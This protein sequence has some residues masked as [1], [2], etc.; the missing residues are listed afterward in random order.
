MS[1]RVSYIL[2]GVMVL[3]LLCAATPAFATNRI[4]L[5]VDKPSLTIGDLLQAEVVVTLEDPDHVRNITFPDFEGFK[6][7]NKS[8]GR[9]SYTSIVNFKMTSQDITTTT[10]VLQPLKLGEFTLGPASFR[11]KGRLVESN[12]ARVK[13]IDLKALSGQ[14][15]AGEMA[16]SAPLSDEEALNPGYFARFIP[17]RNQLVQGEQMAATLYL[18]IANTQINRW[19]QVA[20]PDFGGFSAERLE[21]PE[22]GDKRRLI[23]GNRQYHVEALDRYLLT[24]RTLGKQVLAPY[25]LKVML[26]GDGFFGGR[27]QNIRTAPVEVTIDP[28]PERE[29]QAPLNSSLVGQFHLQA[30]IDRGRT[31]VGQPVALTLRL[32]GN[33]NMDDVPLP[34]LP[35]I[36]NTKVYPPT[37]KKE[38]IQH[39]SRIEGTRTA[40]YLIVPNKQGA[41]TI[42][43]ISFE[44]YDTKKGGYNTLQTRSYTF[45]AVPSKGGAA[46]S[47]GYGGVIKQD[48]AIEEG[49][50]RPLR[51]SAELTNHN[52]QFF[53]SATFWG[54]LLIPLALVSMLYLL[55]LLRWLLPRIGGGDRAKR[56]KELKSL[57]ADLDARASKVDKSFASDLSHALLGELELKLNQ[58]LSGLT[59]DQLEQRL[60]L[61]EI[62]QPWRANLRRLLETC[63][64]MRYAPNSAESGQELIGRARQLIKELQA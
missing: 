56:E 38:N 12:T 55:D 54:L 29:G 61:A 40:E 13:V 25:R 52:G 28:L 42:P 63:D 30:S 10:F 57:W 45:M 46:S 33:R 44:Y 48:L 16:I 19:G 37:E 18:Y 64:F 3:L 24:A 36:P 2:M 60:S 31:E 9:Q 27:W 49:A 43:S 8:S 11:E 14:Q 34:K 1:A 51:P 58:T 41:Y 15:A 50:L 62:P 6:V 20:P 7:I 53:A 26:G 35:T 59:L 23:I 17:E 4:E 39:G 47:T 22:R 5:K 21:L 32:N